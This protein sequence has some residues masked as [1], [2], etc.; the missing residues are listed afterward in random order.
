MSK[1]HIKSAK[2]ILYSLGQLQ[3]RLSN[4]DE[5]TSQDVKD[6]LAMQITRNQEMALDAKLIQC[7]KQH[8]RE[9]KKLLTFHFQKLT[10]KLSALR[11]DLEQDQD[12][13]SAQDL[14]AKISHLE[15]ELIQA[16]MCDIDRISNHSWNKIQSGLSRGKSVDLSDNNTDS[17]DSTQVG[18]TCKPLIIDDNSKRALLRLQEDK[19]YKSFVQELKSDY[20]AFKE[21]V[22]KVNKQHMEKR[23]EDVDNAKVARKS[24]SQP[25]QTFKRPRF[26]PDEIDFDD[27]IED[28][29]VKA[30][31]QQQKKKKNRPGQQ[32]RKRSYLEQIG[33]AKGRDGRRS[34]TTAAGRDDRNKQSIIPD[35][36]EKQIESIKRNRGG[37]KSKVNSQRSNT[38]HP[39]WEAKKKL[40]QAGIVPSAGVKIKFDSDGE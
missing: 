15:T 12:I 3:Q 30:L 24:N 18:D 38:L 29:A 26:D 36:R 10:K 21:R 40:Q 17:D 13:Q 11:S 20:E 34:H 1:N 6:Q 33:S 19:K 37:V 5:N 28:P 9:I 8:R 35:R 4:T 31:E 7:E 22:F 32:A 23:K 16:K 25:R 14:K 39:S 27:L 2:S